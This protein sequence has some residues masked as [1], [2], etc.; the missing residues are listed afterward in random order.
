MRVP[1]LHQ[2]TA[3]GTIGKAHKLTQLTKSGNMAGLA[4]IPNERHESRNISLNEEINLF[5]SFF[6][7]L[8]RKGYMNEQDADLRRVST[9]RHLLRKLR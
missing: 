5:M 7:T 1:V 8:K 3:Q 6:S 2:R 4:N 9:G